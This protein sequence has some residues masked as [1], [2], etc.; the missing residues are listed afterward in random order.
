MYGFM[1]LNW[2]VPFRIT[3]GTLG[4]GNSVVLTVIERAVQPLLSVTVTW[5]EPESVTAMERV[6]CPFDQV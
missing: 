5:K 1:K 3:Y 6:V 2:F 4:A